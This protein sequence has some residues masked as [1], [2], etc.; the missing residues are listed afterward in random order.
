[1]LLSD[2]KLRDFKKVFNKKVRKDVSNKQ[3]FK[4]VKKELND[5]LTN[6]GASLR[7]LPNL[8][9]KTYGKLLYFSY[10]ETTNTTT[11]INLLWKINSLEYEDLVEF[12]EDFSKILDVKT[13]TLRTT[14]VFTYNEL[15]TYWPDGEVILIGEYA[16]KTISEDLVK[17]IL[18]HEIIHHYLYVN[19]KDPSD[20]SED[21]IKMIIEYNAYVSLE[22]EAIKAYNEYILK[23]L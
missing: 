14:D 3:K 13:P 19:G 15:A 8:K 21:F 10:T 22:K 20:T 6:F 4:I 7:S 23:I 2:F 16:Y 18:K 17:K 11:E 5:Y 12:V 1:M 9:I